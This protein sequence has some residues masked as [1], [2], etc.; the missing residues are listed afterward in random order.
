[1]Q[2]AEVSYISETVIWSLW[3]IVVV[4]VAWAHQG[5][6]RLVGVSHTREHNSYCTFFLSLNEGETR[7]Y[8][9]LSHGACGGVCRRPDGWI[10]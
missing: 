7:L 5:R 10:G 6:A 8:A 3:G 9:E 4:V 1:M 2:I